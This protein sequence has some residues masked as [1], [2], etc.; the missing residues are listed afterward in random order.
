MKK[1]ALLF[2]LCIFTNQ[3]KAVAESTNQTITGTI[4]V[5]LSIDLL[6]AD[7]NPVSNSLG[8]GNLVFDGVTENTIQS[9]VGCKIGFPLGKC[10]KVEN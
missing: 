9:F 3:D 2:L 4:G 10:W 5:N 6:D 7:N 1:I 8:F